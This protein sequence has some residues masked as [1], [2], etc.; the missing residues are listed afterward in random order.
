MIRKCP[1]CG[2]DMFLTSSKLWWCPRCGWREYA[3]R[4]AL[5]K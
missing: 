3:Q 5:S 2:G 4:E 1:K